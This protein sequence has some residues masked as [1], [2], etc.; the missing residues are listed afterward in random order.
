MTDSKTQKIA[1]IIKKL[2]K[3]KKT[4]EKY[5][6]QWPDQP[7]S[8][9]PDPLGKPDYQK[10]V[11]PIINDIELDWVD[12]E[13]EISIHWPYYFPEWPDLGM[14]LDIIRNQRNPQNMDA[15]IQGLRLVGRKLEIKSQPVQEQKPESAEA[16]ATDT[17]TGK[18]RK[19]KR[20]KKTPKQVEIEVRE[21]QARGL[22]KNQDLTAEKLGE[23]LGCSAATACRTDAWQK[24]QARKGQYRKSP[25]GFKRDR[26]IDGPDIEAIADSPKDEHYDI[27]EM[28]DN[29]NERKS[30]V[31]PN[32]ENIAKMLF[33]DEHEA[34][35]LFKETQHFFQ[36]VIVNFPE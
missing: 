32:T 10:D 20:K 17:K 31:I 11:Q 23:K 18:K 2:E 6:A 36:D 16:L 1:A 27:K 26:R 9:R 24:H 14:A 28:V 35:R 29:Y 21:Q 5:Y 12:V 3:L 22:L 4:K 30:E 8:G 13:D 25:D 7:I 34:E 19:S 15:V 33:V